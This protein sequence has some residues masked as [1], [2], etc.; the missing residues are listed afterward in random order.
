M[1]PKA[2]EDWLGQG[3]KS[4]RV[5][6]L[7]R[8][9]QVL[10]AILPDQ[11]RRDPALA[12]CSFELWEPRP[13]FD[14]N[15]ERPQWEP[16]ETGPPEETELDGLQGVP[17]R[18]RSHFDLE[19]WFL[20]G[21]SFPAGLSSEHNPLRLHETEEVDGDEKERF[22][23]PSDVV[24]RPDDWT[25]VALLPLLLSAPSSPRIASPIRIWLLLT[26]PNHEINMASGYWERVFFGLREIQWLLGE[27]W[28]R[29]FEWILVEEPVAV[30]GLLGGWETILGVLGGVIEVGLPGATAGRADTGPGT[31][32]VIFPRAYR[33]VGEARMENPA[34][35]LLSIVHSEG[36]RWVEDR[37]PQWVPG[38]LTPEQE[39][40]WEELWGMQAREFRSM[41]FWYEDRRRV[42]AYLAD[43]VWTGGGWS[44]AIERVVKDAAKALFSDIALKEVPRVEDLGPEGEVGSLPGLWA[45]RIEK[46]QEDA[47]GFLSSTVRLFENSAWPGPWE[48]LQAGKGEAYGPFLD[49]KIDE[50]TRRTELLK[51]SDLLGGFDCVG[52]A[53]HEAEKILEAMDEGGPEPSED[54]KGAWR[55]ILNR[56][57][58]AVE[59]GILKAALERLD[60][61]RSCWKALQ[62]TSSPVLPPARELYSGTFD[63]SHLSEVVLRVDLG[64]RDWSEVWRKLIQILLREAKSEPFAMYSSIL[65][66]LQALRAGD[67]IHRL[68]WTRTLGDMQRE[69]RWDPG[70]WRF[71]G[72]DGWLSDA[73]Q[74]L[75]GAHSRSLENLADQSVRVFVRQL[76]LQSRTA[77]GRTLASAVAFVS[78]APELIPPERLLSHLSMAEEKQISEQATERF[79]PA[80]PE[81]S[82]A[83]AVAWSTLNGIDSFEVLGK[84]ND[85]GRRAL[86]RLGFGEGPEG[87]ARLP[88]L[89]YSVMRACMVDGHLPLQQ[90]VARIILDLLKAR[91]VGLVQWNERGELSWSSH[92]NVT[93]EPSLSPSPAVSSIEEFIDARLQHLLSPDGYSES[94]QLDRTVDIADPEE[95]LMLWQGLP[96]FL[97][98]PLPIVDGAPSLLRRILRDHQRK[99]GL[100]QQADTALSEGWRVLLDLARVKRG[101][102]WK[103]ALAF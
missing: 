33:A 47:K 89:A 36:L 85:A 30:T 21:K 79:A 67:W 57:S 39:A 18:F 16:A 93:T 32:D 75:I 12:Y 48:A 8:A 4:L 7:G 95:T 88:D 68:A 34:Q 19:D 94:R 103:Q 50:L 27:D 84:A 53:K 2:K 49:L 51:E 80:R 77:Q 17:I 87:T 97:R 15:S 62:S 81:W 44:A 45:S 72:T 64:Y 41:P 58:L 31:R 10:P 37:I 29:G 28:A 54:L 63:G 100:G 35:S 11:L 25:A 26:R 82:M 14:S 60:R 5:I 55:G 76:E 65:D 22:P 3:S 61:S 71:V 46:L 74:I 23:L 20:T 52:E 99:L 78:Y 9:G 40:I 86:R 92:N 90:A 24:L 13:S 96:D 98:R 66:S 73:P 42:E 102:P 91:A 70:Y 56:L 1:C 43:K 38:S 101:S 83:R 59:N 69:G 6:A